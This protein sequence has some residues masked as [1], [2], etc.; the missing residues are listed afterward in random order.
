MPRTLLI[1]LL[2]ASSSMN[3]A[4]SSPEPGDGHGKTRMGETK[5]DVAKDLFLETLINAPTADTD[6]AVFAFS[7]SL[8]SLFYGPATNAM[9]VEGLIRSL[10]AEGSANLA[11]AFIELERWIKKKI[12]R[13]SVFGPKK[14][15][16]IKVL[17]FS[18]GLTDPDL[19]AQ[20]FHTFAWE[21]QP[22]PIDIHFRLID[23]T[24]QGRQTQRRVVKGTDDR[25][26]E[27]KNIVPHFE[28]IERVKT[29]IDELKH[30]EPDMKPLR[31]PAKAPLSGKIARSGER[32]RAL[33]KEYLAAHDM[34]AMATIRFAG[35]VAHPFN[36]RLLAEGILPA[37]SALETIQAAG[38]KTGI[39]PDVQILSISRTS[40]IKAS[41]S[42]IAK[43]VEVLD[44]RF[45]PWKRENAKKMKQLEIDKLSHEVRKIKAEARQAE[46][47]LD[48][49][50]HESRVKELELRKMEAEA[51]RIEL[52]NES[53][54]L[55][56]EEQKIRQQLILM[57]HTITRSMCE[58]LEVS[59]PVYLE[60]HASI[61][62]ALTQLS[63]TAYPM[64]VVHDGATAVTGPG[65]ER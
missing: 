27:E 17:V 49:P 44:E 42:G 65:R 45:T 19:A 43:A 33:F 36:S 26:V 63:R 46:T 15:A 22:T 52:E 58:N 39:A 23:S 12:R 32:Q 6:I 34:P 38:E 2:D 40:D 28:G 11:D 64:E 37:I 3:D 31:E 18:D 55:R 54:R 25:L 50:D 9:D 41:V 13:F 53:R 30:H 16:R 21:V 29:L 47:A 57:A 1:A 35:S 5:L 20:G 56:I 51:E 62:E 61:L 8:R 7:D 10:K 48:D 60:R 4:F 14:Y 24:P 59:E